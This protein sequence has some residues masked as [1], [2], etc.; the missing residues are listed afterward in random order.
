MQHIT[1]AYTNL[2][3][4]KGACAT[5]RFDLASALTIDCHTGPASMVTPGGTEYSTK[6]NGLLDFVEY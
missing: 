5:G 4:I 1:H 6:Y 3:Y 2:A